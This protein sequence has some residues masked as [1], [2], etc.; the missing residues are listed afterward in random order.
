MQFLSERCSFRGAHGKKLQETKGGFQGS[1]QLSQEGGVL[2]SYRSAGRGFFRKGVVRFSHWKPREPRDETFLCRAN[3]RGGF[4]SQAA[5][6]P[7]GDPRRAPK[8]QTVGTVMASQKMLTLQAIS[9]GAA[10]G[11]AW[12]EERL[13]C[14]PS[15][16]LSPRTAASIYTL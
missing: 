8:K 11:G 10:K 6:D 16:S 9:P 15:G 4:G 2:R 1:R 14:V 7:P 3:G 12:A 5:A 13:F